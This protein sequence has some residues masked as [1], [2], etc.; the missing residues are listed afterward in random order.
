MICNK[1]DSSSIQKAADCL[2]QGGITI[3]PTDTVYGFSGIVDIP[4]KKQFNTVQKI[5]AIKGRQENKALI[6]LI[7]NPNDIY[8]YTNQNIP[9]EILKLWPAPLTII[10]RINQNAE[11]S[12]KAE[13]IAFRCP[14]D[15]WLRKVIE[16]CASPIY[17]TSVNYSGKPILTTS[18]Q[19]IQNFGSKV[20]LFVDDGNKENALPS[21]IIALEGSKIQVLRQGS[22]EISFTE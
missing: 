6:H 5:Y 8:K 2:L 13:T 19:I 1:S 10:V 3:L 16:L 20:D 4:S 9:D 15:L 14:N 17:S 11:L 22:T 18:Q 21:T 12:N 7:A